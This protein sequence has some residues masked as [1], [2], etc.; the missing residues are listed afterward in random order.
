M[1]VVLS[2]TYSVVARADAQGDAVTYFYNML[3]GYTDA[4]ESE[5]DQLELTGP[6]R[7]TYISNCMITAEGGGFNWTSGELYGWESIVQTP[8]WN[9]YNCAEYTYSCAQIYYYFEFFTELELQF[10][11]LLA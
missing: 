11:I 3:L 7:V 4:C 2:M 6:A 9:A 10:S 1:L 5:A 8:G